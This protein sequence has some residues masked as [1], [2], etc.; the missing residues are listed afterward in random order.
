MEGGAIHFLIGL[1]IF[2]GLLAVILFLWYPGILFNVD[3]GWAGLQ[4]VIGVD[5]I[6]GPLLTLVV[7]KTGKRGLNFDLSCIAIFQAV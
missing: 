1:A 7:F 5:L 6:A 2:L 3:R 4:L